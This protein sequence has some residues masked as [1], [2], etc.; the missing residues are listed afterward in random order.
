MALSSPILEDESLRVSPAGRL[1]RRERGLYWGGLLVVCA[2]AYW[3]ARNVVLGLFFIDSTFVLDAGWLAALVSSDS[4][5][6]TIPIA[7]ND[8][9]KP[10]YSIHVSPFFV[11]FAWMNQWQDSPPAEHAAFFFGLAY[12]VFAAF[13][14]AAIID[15]LSHP[16]SPRRLGRTVPVA[17]IA[18]LALS[19]NALAT[20]ILTQVH[21]EIWIPV[22]TGAFLL[23][24][25]SQRLPAAVL[26]FGLLLSV[27]EDAGFHL[28]A[29]LGFVIVWRFFRCRQENPLHGEKN[30]LRRE[31]LWFISALVYSLLAVNLGGQEARSPGVWDERFFV[32]LFSIATRLDWAPVFVVVIVWTLITRH[33]ATL[34]GILSCLPWVLYSVT[35]DYAISANLASY[36]GFPLLVGFFWPFLALRYFPPSSWRWKMMLPNLSFVFVLTLAAVS[37]FVRADEGFKGENTVAA[38]VKMGLGEF[39]GRAV[40]NPLT[41]EKRAGIRQLHKFYIKRKD[42]LDIISMD[43]FGALYPHDVPQASLLSHGHP[44]EVEQTAGKA[45]IAHAG[46]IPPLAA[47]VLGVRTAFGLRHS[48]RLRNTE[49][50]LFSRDPL[51][52]ETV[53]VD[54]LPLAPVP[55]TDPIWTWLRPTEFLRFGFG[56]PAAVLLTE[57]AEADG[58]DAVITQPGAAVRLEAL[59][60]PQGRVGLL[61]EF[62]HD[63]ETGLPPPQLVLN[64]SFGE[65]EVDLP[66]HEKSHSRIRQDIL[67]PEAAP[68]DIRIVHR[69]GGELRVHQIRILPIWAW[70]RFR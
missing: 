14:Y 65:I 55:P 47:S 28:A 18:S 19:F 7:V 17:L 15:F 68:V 59:P 38:F 30:L 64:S 35:Q 56:F 4:W 52:E 63:I 12:A 8:G 39:L 45:L 57:E 37:L 41:P 20:D 44:L 22:L 9:G 53:C 26:C 67:L 60:L 33:W 29:V 51:C 32:R 54:D 69:G 1:S 3:A 13:F 49:F 6:L 48:Y 70:R 50:I 5:R 24:H 16:P 40:D 21:F 31:I 36:Y 11:P 2:A 10:F 46:Q 34:I 43:G 58:K 66:L 62:S 25:I 61:V 42:A 27:R 23:S